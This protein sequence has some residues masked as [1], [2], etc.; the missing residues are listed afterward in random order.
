MGYT[1]TAAGLLDP[2]TNLTYAVRYLAGA[3]RAGGGNADRAVGNYA[4][5]YRATT[6]REGGGIR[7]QA[8]SFENSGPFNSNPGWSNSYASAG[9]IER[10]AWV[11]APTWHYRRRHVMRSQ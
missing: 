5:G 4:R 6:V 10:V 2:E 11:H 9:P 3:Y 8:A 1:D 7:P